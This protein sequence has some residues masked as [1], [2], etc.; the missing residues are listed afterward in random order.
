MN[1]EYFDCFLRPHLGV[2]KGFYHIYAVTYHNIYMAYIIVPVLCVCIGGNFGMTC[3]VDTCLWDMI[4]W[5]NYVRVAYQ[6]KQQ[7]PVSLMFF[8]LVNQV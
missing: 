7:G 3:P 4:C 1:Y 6:G 8:V 5:Y 2:G